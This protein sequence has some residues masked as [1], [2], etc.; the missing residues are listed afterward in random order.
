MRVRSDAFFTIS[1]VVIAA[2]KW[3]VKAVYVAKATDAAT[4][5]ASSS[6]WLYWA[7]S[8]TG[9]SISGITMPVASTDYV[10]TFEVRG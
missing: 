6:S 3:T 4:G 5:T 2:P 1:D 7:V 8:P 10:I 9:I